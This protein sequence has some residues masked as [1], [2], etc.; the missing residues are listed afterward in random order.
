M[1][2]HGRYRLGAP[3]G[4]VMAVIASMLVVQTD[5]GDDMFMVMARGSAAQSLRLDTPALLG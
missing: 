1:R 3:A 4:Y 5:R 2:I